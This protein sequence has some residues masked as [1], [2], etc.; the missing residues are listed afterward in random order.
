VKALLLSLIVAFGLIRSALAQDATTDTFGT[1]ANQFT[2]DFTAIGNAGNAADNTGYGSVGYT[3]RMGT[4]AISQNQIDAAT[5]SGMQ[6]VVA[7]AWRGD[8]PA[9]NMS[10]YEAAAFVNWLNTSKGFHPAYNLS[11]SKST[12]SMALWKSTEAGYDANNL[13]RN[14]LAKYFLPSENEFCKAAWGKKNG[15]GYYDYSTASN[16]PPDSVASGTSAG[17]GVFKQ[18]SGQGPA[19][20]YEAGG[21]SSYGTMGQGGNISQWLES[22]WDGINNSASESRGVRGGSWKDNRYG[23]WFSSRLIYGNSPDFGNNSLGFRV[24]SIADDRPMSIPT[25]TVTFT[26]P[27]TPMA[28]S[29]GANFLLTAAS[30][31]GGA[32]TYTSS[33]PNVISVSGK[34]ATIRGVGTATLTATVA[35]IA[36]YSSATASR[37]VTVNK[38]TPTVTFTQPTTPV[39]YVDGKTFQLTATST[40]GGTITYSSSNPNVISVSGSTA[41]IKGKGSA[42]L[43]ASVAATVN[44]TSATATRSVT[45][46]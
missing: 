11:W 24:A 46:K 27:I 17:T 13:Y 43:T 22:A 12:W 15:K 20:V 10:W 21:L 33:N 16:T 7:G 1:G 26:Q 40:S 42:I 5:A 25:P 39:V 8:Q 4:Y 14:S 9:A 34:T 41:T 37:S 31:S 45:V 29:Y 3:Y 28:Y 2:L 44:Y 38:I 36:N 23:L 18:S 19:S 30:T 6:N 35:A 32:V